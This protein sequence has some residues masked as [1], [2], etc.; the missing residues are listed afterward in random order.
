MCG[1]VSTVSTLVLPI[2]PGCKTETRAYKMLL[3]S[4]YDCCDAGAAAAPERSEELVLHSM[5][6]RSE[7]PGAA[8]S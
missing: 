1:S 2:P 8:P 5:A 6:Q 3:V 7:T 4:P